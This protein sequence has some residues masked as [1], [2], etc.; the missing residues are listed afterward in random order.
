MNNKLFSASSNFGENQKTAMGR[1]E[2]PV[3]YCYPGTCANYNE[4]KSTDTISFLHSN[5]RTI[6]EKFSGFNFPSSPHFFFLIK[7]VCAKAKECG[8]SLSQVPEELLDIY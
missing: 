6:Y 8:R 7:R 1:K 3:C 4:V 5:R 2:E